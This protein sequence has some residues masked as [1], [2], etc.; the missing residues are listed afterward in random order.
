MTDL[1]YIALTVVF[2]ALVIAYA[3]GCEALGRADSTSTERR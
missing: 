2:F 3:R 1:L